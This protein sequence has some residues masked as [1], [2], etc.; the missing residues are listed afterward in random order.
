MYDIFVIIGK[1]VV[2]FVTMYAF[3]LFSLIIA[4]GIKELFNSIIKS[5]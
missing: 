1:I 4:V 3:V 5:K 2:V